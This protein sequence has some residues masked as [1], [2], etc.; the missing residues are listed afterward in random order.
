MDIQ[1]KPIFVDKPKLAATHTKALQAV[2]QMK[3]KAELIWVEVSEEEYAED[4]EG[5]DARKL[6]LEQ[7]TPLAAQES[8][9][10]ISQ[11]AALYAWLKD[12]SNI[13]W[14]LFHI[15]VEVFFALNSDSFDDLDDAIRQAQK[16][17][18]NNG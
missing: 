7:P 10:E 14:D 18:E 9:E 17:C 13:N 16:Q 8:F 2:Y 15:N 11:Q 4:L 6:Y 3:A 5:Y 1:S 12:N